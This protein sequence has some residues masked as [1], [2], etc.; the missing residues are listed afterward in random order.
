VEKSFNRIKCP[1]VILIGK[2]SFSA[3]EDFLV[4]IYEVPD[5]PLLIGETTGGS[6]G[7][8]LVLFKLPNETIARICTLRIL[9]PY[10]MKPFVNK[11]ISPDIEIKE[12]IEDYINGNDV[13]LNRAIQS[14]KY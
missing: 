6:T 13:C 11:G 5:R 10:S 4:N 1:V 2:L 8:P 7:A 3:C 12:T 9:Y 14:L